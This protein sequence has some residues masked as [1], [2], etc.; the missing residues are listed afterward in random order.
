MFCLLN[1]YINTSYLYFTESVLN[2]PPCIRVMVTES[3]L[4]DVGTLFIVTVSGATIGREK[5]LGHAIHI[6]DQ[7]ISKVRN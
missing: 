2:W 3:D 5:S 6:P 1:I 4:L 7:Q